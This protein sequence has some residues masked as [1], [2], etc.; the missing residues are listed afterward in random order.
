[1]ASRNIGLV[2]SIYEGWERGDVSSADWA[3]PHIEFVSPMGVE[4]GSWIGRSEMARAW[5]ETI[6]AWDEIRVKADEFYELDDERVLT[7]HTFTGRGKSSG[8][9]IGSALTNGATLFQIRDGKVTRLV[10]YMDRDRAVADVGL[11]PRA[12]VSPRLPRLIEFQHSGHCGGALLSAE[13]VA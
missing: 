7:F 2:R 6:S 13:A 11:A 1:M 10:V 9:A 3:D 4:T 5:G 12:D 8:I